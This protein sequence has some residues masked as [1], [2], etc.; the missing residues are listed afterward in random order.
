MGS[1]Y[2]NMVD[3][4][5]IVIDIETVP[6]KTHIENS[7]CKIMNMESF[8]EYVEY[9]NQ[10]VKEGKTWFPKPIFHKIVNIGMLFIS[11]NFNLKYL[12]FYGED[13]QSILINFWEIFEKCNLPYIV[14][15]NGKSFDMPV[16][17]NNSFKYIE[18]FSDK[19]LMGFHLYNDKSDK[20]ENNRPNYLNRF[21]NYHIDIMDNFSN[22]KPSLIEVCTKYGIQVK[23]EGHGSEIGNMSEEEI[24]KYCKEDVIATTK[25]FNKFAMANF[26]NTEQY[27]A[28][29][30]KL[31]LFE[32]GEI[33]DDK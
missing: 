22:P 2:F 31:E 28:L 25:V 32:N 21:S 10:F 12:D 3:N 1:E 7:V 14:S 19:A 33:E 27:N 24:R 17:V 8:D 30:E 16:I 13:E 18:N 6:D 4:N 29:K 9:E 11:I 20:W 26:F 23:T 15:F 5:I